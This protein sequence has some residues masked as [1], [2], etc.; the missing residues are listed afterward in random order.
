MMKNLSFRN[1]LCDSIELSRFSHNGSVNTVSQYSDFQKKVANVIPREYDRPIVHLEII[2]DEFTNTGPSIAIIGGMGPLSDA[3]LIQRVAHTLA[4][5]NCHNY[6]LD[7]LSI[8]P[9]RSIPHII[10]GGSQYLYHLACF[11]RSK[12]FTHV[13]LASN[14]AHAYYSYFRSFTPP[15]SLVDLTNLVTIRLSQS[16]RT[17]CTLILGTVLGHQHQLYERQFQKVALPYQTLPISDQSIIQE[18]IDEV[19]TLY[20]LN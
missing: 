1:F 16:S 4:E 20:K 8:P 5:K 18:L 15:S 17:I 7:L 12:A 19:L 13:Y 9:P 2:S 6:Q 3:A 14:T 10:F 11:L